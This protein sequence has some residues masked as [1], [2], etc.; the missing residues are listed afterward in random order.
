MKRTIKLKVEGRLA[1]IVLKTWLE[2]RNL[3]DFEVD[4]LRRKLADNLMQAVCNLP[5]TDFGPSEVKVD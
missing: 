3:A 4:R 2:T 1:S 5:Y